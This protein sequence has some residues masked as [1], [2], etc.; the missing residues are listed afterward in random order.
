MNISKA[1]I[2][3]AGFGSRFLPI[4]K[5]FPKELLP[6]IDKPIIHH[7]VDECAA[8]GI[9]EVIIVASPAEVDKF[10]DYFLGRAINIRTLMIRQH[11][12]ERWSKVEKVFNLPNITIVPQDDSIPYGNGRPLL[13]VKELLSGE[14]AF[15]VMFGDDLVVGETSAAKQLVD[16]YQGNQ[17]DALFAVQEVPAESVNRF[18]IVES[19][20]ETNRVQTIVEKPE[21]GT[22]PSNLASYGR[23][24][25]TP[26]IFDYLKAENTGKDDELWL[27]DACNALIKEGTG[28]FTKIDGTWMT[29]GDPLSYLQ[30][31]IKVALQDEELGEKLREFLQE[32]VS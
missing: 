24:I 22:A 9:S 14:E 15:L 23:Y 31:H 10:E 32:E 8:A 3:A 21:I 29:T 5:S 1:V 6:I 4:T 19:D 13:S 7:L 16:Y 26:R 30:A 27:M 25:F 2:T 17:C 18:G 20:G 28:L 12:L 11:K